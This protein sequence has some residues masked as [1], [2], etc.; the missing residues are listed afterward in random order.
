MIMVAIPNAAHLALRNSH[1]SE[2]FYVSDI[3]IPT[4]AHSIIL[5][6][7]MLDFRHRVAFLTPTSEPDRSAT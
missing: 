6:A 5:S 2:Q 3:I 1:S 7:A 4:P